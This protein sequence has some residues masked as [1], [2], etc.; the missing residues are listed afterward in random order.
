MTSYYDTQKYGIS[1]Y[2]YPHLSSYFWKSDGNDV[3]TASD[4]GYGKPEDLFGPKLEWKLWGTF[5]S[6]KALKDSYGFIYSNK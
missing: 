5:I 2:G 6:S 1:D 3:Y 4:Y